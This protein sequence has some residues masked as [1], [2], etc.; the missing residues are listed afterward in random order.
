[1]NEPIMTYDKQTR[2][3]WWAA[4]RDKFILYAAALMFG[5]MLWQIPSGI[6][7]M[8][9]EHVKLLLAVQIQCV[10]DAKTPTER[11]ECLTLELSR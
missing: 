8:R 9:E 6:S 1:M 10:H 2:A 11:M 7:A 3:P 5:V 4:N